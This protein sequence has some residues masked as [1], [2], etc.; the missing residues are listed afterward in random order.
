M[1]AADDA[2]VID[3]TSMTIDEVVEKVITLS[4][5]VLQG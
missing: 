4:K 3:T 1:R 5:Q 2:I